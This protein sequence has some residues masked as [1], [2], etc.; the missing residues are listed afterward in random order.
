V[1]IVLL[2][3]HSFIVVVSCFKLMSVIEEQISKTHSVQFWSILCT[4]W[5]K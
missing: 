2:F 5:T 4:D 1:V 3:V